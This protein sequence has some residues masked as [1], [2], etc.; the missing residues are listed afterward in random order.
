MVKIC[1][2]RLPEWNTKTSAWS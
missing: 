1:Y 2:L